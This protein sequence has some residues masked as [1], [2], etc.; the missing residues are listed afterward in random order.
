MSETDF[1]E[2]EDASEELTWMHEVVKNGDNK[3][4]KYILANNLVN[5]NARDVYRRTSLHYTVRND[6]VECVKI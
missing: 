4:F 2:E 6:A 5:V 3:M 1:E